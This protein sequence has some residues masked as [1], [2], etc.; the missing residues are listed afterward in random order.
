MTIPLT[1]FIKGINNDPSLF[2]SYSYS[3]TGRIQHVI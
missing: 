3:G 1:W 2:S